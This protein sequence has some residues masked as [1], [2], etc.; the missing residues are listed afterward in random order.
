MKHNEN[1]QQRNKYTCIA[2]SIPAFDKT[3]P[4]TPPTVKSAIKPTENSI[5]AI[6]H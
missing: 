1:E 5:E 3:T 6:K 4:V 2:I